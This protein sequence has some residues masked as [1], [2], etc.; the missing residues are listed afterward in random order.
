MGGG[1]FTEEECGQATAI[2]SV[3]KVVVSKVSR[4]CLKGFS[5]MSGSFRKI[6]LGV[7]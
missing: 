7:V 6:V 2:F 5:K 3:E 1:H 4:M